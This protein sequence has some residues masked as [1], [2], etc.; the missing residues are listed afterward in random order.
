MLRYVLRRIVYGVITLLLVSMLS[1]A[2]LELA[3]GEFVDE[4]RTDPRVSAETVEAL[5]ERYGLTASLPVRYARWLGGAVQGDFGFS[6][7]YHTPVSSLIRERA[8]NTLLLTVPA[9]VFSWLAAVGVAVWA[10]ARP[11]R[12]TDRVLDTVTSALLAVPELLLGLLVLLL[13]LRTGWFP[14][15]G[16]ASP[17]AEDFDTTARLG[18]LARHAFLPLSVLVAV[19]FPAVLR[20]AR[21][22]M[23]EA[24]DAPAVHA[25][26]GHGVSRARL[27][28]RYALPIAANPLVSLAGLSAATLLSASFLVEVI[29]SWPGLGPL[30]LEAIMARDLHLVVM[31]SL[32]SALLLVASNLMADILLLVLD[33]RIART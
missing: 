33:P 30:L 11:G 29:M 8:L 10:S 32:V 4:M 21:A 28:Y 1:F 25:A 12:W 31:A 26:R 20:H 6:F 7:A 2:F 19:T 23:G 27:L 18:D 24:L 17:G 13:A 22:S 9:I 5:R 3:P 16:M 15:G 14:T